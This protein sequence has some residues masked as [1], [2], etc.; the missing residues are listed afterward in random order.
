LLSVTL[1]SISA[2]VPGDQMVCHERRNPPLTHLPG[3]LT[4]SVSPLAA[5][6]DTSSPSVRFRKRGELDQ[7]SEGLHHNVSD[8]SRKG[9][10]RLSYIRI[11]Y[12]IDQP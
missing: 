7:P 11:R 3:D 9:P 6:E 12:C 10:P 1:V 5:Q 4:L 8:Q 2:Y